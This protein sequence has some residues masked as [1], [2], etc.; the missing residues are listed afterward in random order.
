MVP[1]RVELTYRPNLSPAAPFPCEQDTNYLNQCMSTGQ[2]VSC[3]GASGL[4]WT[5]PLAASCSTPFTQSNYI[6]FTYRHMIHELCHSVRVHASFCIS[7]SISPFMFP[8]PFG[9]RER[10]IQLRKKI[11]IKY[12]H[13]LK[14]AYFRTMHVHAY[15]HARM[16]N[17][18]VCAHLL[19][20]KH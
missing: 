20:R 15:A 8:R 18:C 12:I 2:G 11:H 14:Y 6:V 7:T 9:G 1:G 5:E 13:A 17:V 3:V 4:V 19:D 10:L 16:C